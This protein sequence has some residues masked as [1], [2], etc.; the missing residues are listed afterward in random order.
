[1]NG[2]R[3][4]KDS[5][6]IVTI[7]MDMT[8]PVNTMN[9]EFIQLIEPTLDR[10][11]KEKNTITGVILTSAKKTFFAGG[12][13]KKII[14]FSKGQ[15]AEIFSFL[16]KNKS[17]LRRLE[18]LGRPVVAAIN[19]SALGGGC[20]LC[21]ACH[22]RIIMDDPAIRIGMPEVTLGLLPGGGGIVRTIRMM[23][24]E[25][26]LPL[27]VEGKKLKPQKALSLGL[28]DA[29]AKNTEEMMQK[30]AEWIKAHPEAVQPWDEKGY[31][32]PG[33]DTRDKK[34][35]QILQ[36]APGMIYQKT[37]GNMPA[38]ETILDV[39]GES[40]RLDVDTA[41]RIESRGFTKL[42]LTPVAKN[43]I[44]TFFFQMNELKAGRSRPSG[45]KK[46][47]VKRVGILGAG[48]M[49]QGLAYVS[50]MAGVEAVLKDISLEAAQKGKTYSDKLLSKAVKKSRITAERKK[51]VLDLITPTVENKNLAGCDLIIEAVFEDMDLK[52]KVIR[53]TE[54]NLAENGIFASNTSTLP[55]TQLARASERA[56][57][58]I[59]LHFFSPVDKMPLVEIIL[60]KQ[61]S[62]KTLARG[63]DFVRQIRKVPIVVNDARGFFT[64]RVF[65]TFLDEGCRMVK[66]G[67][68]PILI[69]TMGRQAGMPVGP[70]TVHDEVTQKLILQVSETNQAL[71]EKFNHDFNAT[72]PVMAE[73]SSIL[74]KD[75][76]RCGRVH[77][78]GW[79][80]YH[81]N[82]KKEIWPKL[83]KLFY[84]SDAALP[85][86]DIKDRMIFRQSI[87]SV[88]CCSEGVVK[89]VGD[90]NIGS[91]MG[92]GFPPH[93][94]GV[95]Q[96]IN[97]YGVRRFAARA[98]QL[99]TIY[100]D[101][102]T[103]PELLL[104]KSER[105]ELF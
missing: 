34:T 51:I 46:H 57:N 87:E 15:E 70:L 3:Y 74:V 88:R 30:A 69:D 60:G 36:I 92:I 38:P 19:G 64:S 59:G 12:D 75:H 99:A 100:G 10:L 41:L 76:G 91:I 103:P 44:T 84:S 77:G 4:N 39:A 50:A 21:L 13:L 62:D 37:R 79:Y 29:V 55:I 31:K 85:R 66:E 23:G 2:F 94:G 72:N 14:A 73:M 27:L 48:M 96:Y 86:Q 5:D 80:D 33:G 68:D 1:M 54:P 18:Q 6:N 101:R 9:E 45:V 20:E 16:E 49:G 93:T 28:V 65:G 22:H 7:L 83:Y 102:F 71:D 82:G 52:H 42:A 26:A 32:I 98:R 35:I 24:L 53:E 58:F 61:T 47:P 90:A 67:L 11:E 97:T 95:L 25:K 81:K 17:Y 105:D 43:L 40:L 63:F 104:E 56:E 8:G 78:G 89:S